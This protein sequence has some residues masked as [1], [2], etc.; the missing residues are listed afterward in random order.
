MPEI[1]DLLD[2]I[3]AETCVASREPPAHLFRSRG[4]NPPLLARGAVAAPANPNT[5]ML[6][7]TPARTPEMLSSITG[8][9]ASDNC[10]RPAA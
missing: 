8:H 3:R 1:I 9:C 10:M 5:R 4:R 7:G 2:R 6:A